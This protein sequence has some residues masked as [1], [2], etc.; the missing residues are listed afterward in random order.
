MK[1][2]Q[3]LVTTIRVGSIA[4][5]WLIIASSI[6]LAFLA[7]A[8]P[9][10]TV[11]TWSPLIAFPLGGCLMASGF[12]YVGMLGQ[13]LSRS[14]MHRM[15]AGSLLLAPLMAGIRLLLTPGHQG[16]HPFGFFLFVPACLSF[17]AAVWPFRPT[18]AERPT[19]TD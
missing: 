15:L 8:A 14:R 4:V 7:G 17:L 18:P 16:L 12:L 1:L 5:G 19:T 9:S 13:S 10:D 3:T 6:P 11:P 2:R